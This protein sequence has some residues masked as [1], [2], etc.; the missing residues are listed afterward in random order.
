MMGYINDVGTANPHVDVL[1][2]LGEFKCLGRLLGLYLNTSKTRILISTSSN[3]AL[4]SIKKEY[5]SVIAADLRK[6]ISIY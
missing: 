2:F 1:F 4:A 3:S 5:G 6:A